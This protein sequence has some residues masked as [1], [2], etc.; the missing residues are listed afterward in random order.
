MNVQT[1]YEVVSATGTTLFT[2]PD[3]DLAKDWLRDR[4]AKVPGLNM[5]VDEVIRTEARRR[6]YS[7]RL[8]VVEAA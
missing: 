8:R 3:K 6:V 1:D 7:S 2:S 5:R 4:V